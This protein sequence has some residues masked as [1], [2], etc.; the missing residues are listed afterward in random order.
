MD[1]QVLAAQYAYQEAQ[2]T[3]REAV[4]AAETEEDGAAEAVGAAQA[5]FDAAQK[6]L[7]EALKKAHEEANKEA[8]RELTDRVTLARYINIANPGLK[9]WKLDGAESELNRELDIPEGYF[10]IDVLMP[11]DEPEQ[12]ADSVTTISTSVGKQ[13]RPIAE[14][15]FARDLIGRLG[16]SMPAVSPGQQEFTWLT[17]GATAGMVA[18]GASLDVAAAT[19]ALVSLQPLRMTSG[20]LIGDESLLRVGANLEAVVKDDIRKAIAD[21]LNEQVLTGNGTSPNLNGIFGRISGTGTQVGVAGTNATWQQMRGIPWG[22]VDDKDYPE[23]NSLLMVLG[24][25]TMRYGHTLFDTNIHQVLDGIQ[26]IQSLGTRVLYSSHMPAPTTTGNKY[27]Y[28]LIIAQPQN[29]VTP[30][31]RG[32][33]AHMFYDASIAQNRFDM[34]MY[35]NQT[36]IKSDANKILGFT[37]LRIPITN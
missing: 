11:D 14:R 23:P 25:A 4:E 8:P 17:A 20:I 15:V 36:Y 10:P 37:K 28:G 9:D 22:V 18:E 7:M 6:T 34:N 21:K 33:R 26:A 13:T 5:A 16:I 27:Q 29:V 35:L 32:I 2:V 1:P 31:W 19:L 24:L 3:L 30:I 12:R